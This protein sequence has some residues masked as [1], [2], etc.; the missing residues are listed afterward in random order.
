MAAAADRVR[1]CWPLYLTLIVVA[2]IPL[3][4]VGVFVLRPYVHVLDFEQSACNSTVVRQTADRKCSCGE[5]CVSRYPCYI[6]QVDYTTID[7]TKQSADIYESEG[8]LLHGRCTFTVSTCFSSP[9]TNEDIINKK[10][11]K[12]EEIGAG[13]TCYYNPLLHSEV[14]MDRNISLLAVINGM[15]WP[16]L[17]ISICLVLFL[18]S[19]KA[20]KC[21]IKK[22][23]E[24]V[25]SIT[26]S[27]DQLKD[28]EEQ[29]P[30]YN[31]V[32][33]SDNLDEPPTYMESINM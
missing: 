19:V 31:Q 13:Y 22:R 33:S 29:L 14:I 30:D 1:R 3:S 12:Q 18:Y 21:C 17:I 4:F 20:N 26:A 23:Q 25:A 6:V 7:G 15:F 28:V 10:L 24:E 27:R 32:I 8:V 5:G 11:R 16:S 9:S 2:I